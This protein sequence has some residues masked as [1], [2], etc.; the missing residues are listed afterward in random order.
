M[1]KITGITDSIHSSPGVKKQQANSTQFKETLAK[2]LRPESGNP[3]KTTEAG[4]LGEI[5]AP[6]FRPIEDSRQSLIDRTNRL[7]DT[8]EQYARDLNNPSKTL[9]EI[10]PLVASL[11]EEADALV[12][13]SEDS[14]L[15]D[16]PLKETVNRSA[17]TAAVEY[18]KFYRGDYI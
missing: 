5:Q 16:T 8:L 13:K 12:T 9:R 3:A 2:A 17:V 14:E 11:K 1:T 7:L 10:E 18:M 15:Q 6:A 4:S